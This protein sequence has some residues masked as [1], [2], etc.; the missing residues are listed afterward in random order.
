MLYPVNIEDKLG[1]TVIRELLKS[2]CLSP[3]G[4]KYCEK[5]RFSFDVQTVEKLLRQ[6]FEFRNILTEQL[7]FPSTNYIDVTVS[8]KKAEIDGA[9]LEAAEFFDFKLS[10]RTI[11][12][13][14]EFFKEREAFPHL[15]QLSEFVNLDKEIYKEVDSVIDDKGL[16][17]DNASEEL[18]EIRRNLIAEQSRLRK[19]LDRIIRYAKREGY[20]E[21]DIAITIRNGRMVIP[22]LSEHKRKIKG[23]VHDESAT[24]Q[25][26]FLEPAEVLEVNN[27][28]KELEYKERREIQRIL[29]ALTRFIRPFLPELHKAWQF[30]GMLDF[31]RAKAKLA[32]SL[33]ATIPY[34]E[35]K[36]FLKW[37]KARHPLLFL[38]HKKQGKTVVPLNIHLSED[39]R[40]LIISGPNAGGKSV[41]LK[42]VGLLQYMLQCGLLVPVEEG[43]T[44]GIFQDVFIDI[45]D[46]QSIENDLS[47][48][49]SH[50]TNMK[51]FLFYAGKKSLILIDEFGTGTEP[52]LGAAIAEAV[53]EKL[54][55]KLVWGVITTHYANLKILADKLQGLKNAAMRFDMDNLEP[56][57]ELDIGRPGSSFAFE[58]AGKIGLPNDVLEKSRQKAGKTQVSFEK[59]VGELEVEKEKLKAEV[60]SARHKN[61]KLDEKFQQYSNL[62]EDL[63]VNR[64]KLLNEAKEKARQI[65]STANQKIEQAIREIKEKDADKEVSKEVRKDLE[66]FKITL[67]PDHIINDEKEEYEVIGGEISAGDY[68][69]VKDTGAVGEV[70]SISDK[71]A[72]IMIGEL[73]SIVK[74]NRLEKISRAQFRKSVPVSTSSSGKL[75]N[76][77]MLEFSAVIDVRGKRGE[78]A[79]AMVDDLL[80]SGTMLGVPEIKIIHGRGDGIL[81]NLIRNHLKSY[82]NVRSVSDEHADR[83]GDGATVV[84]LG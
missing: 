5:L 43:S 15:R 38:N 9:F 33:D 35:N 60:E 32:I 54:N 36:R 44:F 41:C 22:V 66:K 82:R 52:Q 50:L 79:I 26:V 34:L 49:S 64:K 12:R 75:I 24:G 63:E 71:S 46:E 69:R 29:T 27:N 58:I 67:K 23:F 16:I 45:G 84:K 70:A 14:V 80:D 30:L 78:E 10:L 76:E 77:K 18:S 55:Q 59:I 40:I 19:E 74:L 83:G 17:R 37:K 25:T 68:V 7:L 21:E 72:E 1:F 3:L 51:N 28:I 4:V 65:V 2:E 61:E 57:Y 47:T 8:L 13:S 39:E 20:T 56:K 6:T 62:K 31:I 11:L 73:K 53:L 48:Y 42:T 81:R